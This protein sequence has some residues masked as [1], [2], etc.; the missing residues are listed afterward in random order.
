[1][2]AAPLTV[3]FFTGQGDPAGSDF[4]APAAA[5]T[6][7]A[8]S[9]E[10]AGF[11]RQFTAAVSAYRERGADFLL[12]R[13]DCT[14]LRAGFAAVEAAFEELSGYV[15]R[16]PAEATEYWMQDREMR[17]VTEHFGA[18]GCEGVDNGSSE[19]VP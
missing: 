18:S 9:V 5:T 1:M 15:A 19:S 12:A 10:L 6:Q 8:R 3:W 16:V 4:Q 2:L 17:E 13:I 7:P 11:E 14:G